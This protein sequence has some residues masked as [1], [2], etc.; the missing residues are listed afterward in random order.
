M[1]YIV[2]GLWHFF[3][4]VQEGE[5]P[6]WR[7]YWMWAQ[8]G[9]GAWGSDWWSWASIFS[10]ARTF[11][12]R[13]LNVCLETNRFCT[14]A[15][16]MLEK[17]LGPWKVEGRDGKD[18]FGVAT[19]TEAE[20]QEINGWT[21]LESPRGNKVPV[22]P[23]QSLW[24]VCPGPQPLPPRL[25]CCPILEY[26]LLP[27]HRDLSWKYHKTLRTVDLQKLLLLACHGPHDDG[28]LIANQGN[29]V[30]VCPICAKSHSLSF[31]LQFLKMWGTEWRLVKLN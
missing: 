30:V 15:T 13:P 19:L 1:K 11:T 22:L 8:E 9:L 14:F 27:K 3:G 5:W 29:F 7:S 17:Q 21:K 25:R 28:L 18:R 10:M 12:I 23:C 24:I 4:T 6:H 26:W 31:W 16:Q 20:Q 2:T